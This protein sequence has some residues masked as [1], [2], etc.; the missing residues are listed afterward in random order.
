MALDHL[1]GPGDS[2]QLPVPDGVNTKLLY[3]GEES[4]DP[5]GKAATHAVTSAGGVL[6]PSDVAECVLAAMDAKEFLILP[7]ANVLDMYRQKCADYDRWLRGMRR[8]Q[9]ALPEGSR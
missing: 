1:R 3:E 9:A 5:R 6:E 7:H 8:Y 4:D 2:S